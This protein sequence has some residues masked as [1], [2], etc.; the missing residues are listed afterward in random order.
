MYSGWEISHSFELR[1]NASRTKKKEKKKKKDL[2]LRWW[3]FSLRLWCMYV[4]P[5]KSD[6]SFRIMR[7]RGM[8]IRAI[9]SKSFIY[10]F[11]LPLYTQLKNNRARVIEFNACTSQSKFPSRYTHVKVYIYTQV[12]IQREFQVYSD[13]YRKFIRNL[14]LQQTTWI[15]SPKKVN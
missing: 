15:E 14:L 2:F 13:H 11:F 12:C 9:W 4:E 5:H 7:L 8:Y 6:G 1:K 3:M 10:Y